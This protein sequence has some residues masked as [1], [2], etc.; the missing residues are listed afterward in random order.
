MTLAGIVHV[1]ARNHCVLRVVRSRSI[2]HVAWR[3]CG[4]VSVCLELVSNMEWFVVHVCIRFCTTST[5]VVAGGGRAILFD[6]PNRPDGLL[7]GLDAMAKEQA[8]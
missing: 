6:L 3:C 8:R 2:R 7:V 1:I 5:F 4:R